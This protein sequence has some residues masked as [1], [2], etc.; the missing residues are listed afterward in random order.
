MVRSDGSLEAPF[1]P[2]FSSKSASMTTSTVGADPVSAA[3]FPKARR[4]ILGLLYGHPD[5][6]YYLREIVH[7]TG[8]GMGHVQ[9]E[10]RR[11]ARAGVLLESRSGR[12]LY[13]QANES[14]PVYTELRGLVTKT[15]GAL[16]VLRRV[17]APLSSRIPVAFV[18]GSVARAEERSESDLDLMVLGDASFAQVVK[19]VR[20]AEGAIGRAINP[21][22]YPPAEFRAKVKRGHHFLHSVLGGA[23]LFVL[24]DEDELGSLLGKRLD[25]GRRALGRSQPV[26]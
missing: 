9:R 18:F 12:H 16:E 21:S 6:P 11:L 3:L 15:V 13:F 23:K 8:L 22:V 19:A 7:L 1:G 25:P 24:G 4:G 2:P 26:G 20:T 5:R 14:C 17:L 10:T